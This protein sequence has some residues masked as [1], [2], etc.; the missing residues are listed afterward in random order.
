MDILHPHIASL[1]RDFGVV[2]D[3]WWS[4]SRK[5]RQES[6][7]AF[8]DMLDHGDAGYHPF[9]L[10]LHCAWSEGREMVEGRTPSG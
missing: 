10:I 3:A 6:W 9:A 5:E 1:A 2:A 8:T 7:A 4:L